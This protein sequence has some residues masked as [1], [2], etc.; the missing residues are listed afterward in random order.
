MQ[1]K[2]KMKNLKLRLAMYFV[3]L[4]IM[5]LGVSISVKSNLGVSPVSSIPY[6]MTCVWGIEMGKATML[7]HGALVVLQILLLRRS[8]QVKN[9]LQV[10]VGIVFGYYTTFCNWCMTFL[11]APENLALRLAMMLFSTF[12]IALGLFFYVPADI[13][14]MAG[15]G[16]MQTI[17]CLTK[18]PFP[19]VKVA[20]DVTM[21]AISL[22]ICLAVLHKL[23]SVGG[24]TIIAA[25]LVGT[26]L[27]Y[28]TKILG[29]W[30][31][32][33]LQR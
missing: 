27:G 21:V 31:N 19:K 7:F 29:P 5:A 12:L 32:R 20:F 15:E 1:T 22:I 30:R 11:P 23:G 2:M 4:F 25:V 24:G 8:F 33:L 3:G 14:P 6:T 18:I 13:M 10:I 17:S 9:L 28:L 16:A 26:I